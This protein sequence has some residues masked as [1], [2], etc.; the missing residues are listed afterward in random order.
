MMVTP[1]AVR[2]AACLVVLLA[3]CQATPPPPSSATTDLAP[4]AAQDQVAEA[5]GEAGLAV[6]RT[7]DGLRVTT[8]SA[9]F[10]ECLPVMVNVGDGRRVFTQVDERQGVVDIRFADNGRTTATWQTNFTGRYQNRVNNTSFERPCESTG[11]LE[12]LIVRALDR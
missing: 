7:A 4:D 6:D 12:R 11:Q 9:A 2:L 10:V 8:R 5:L 3:A 1:P